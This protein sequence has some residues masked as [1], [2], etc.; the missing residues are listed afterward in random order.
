MTIFSFWRRSEPAV[1]LQQLQASTEGAIPKALFYLKAHPH[2]ALEAALAEKLTA[3]NITTLT[4]SLIKTSPELLETCLKIVSLASLKAIAKVEDVAKHAQDEARFLPKPKVT[5]LAGRVTKDL[6]FNKGTV[7]KVITYIAALISWT[8][9]IDLNKPP[10]DTWSAQSQWMFFRNLI[11]DVEW[12]GTTLLEYFGSVKK[13]AAVFAALITTAT[14]LKYLYHRYN[15]DQ[16]IQLSRNYFRELSADNSTSSIGRV[17]LVQRFLQ[18]ICVPPSIQPNIPILVGPPGVGKTQFVEG[19]AHLAGS[20]KIPRLQGKKIYTV[21]TASLAQHGAW[22]EGEYISRLEMLFRE[23][24]QKEAFV[25]L[26]FDEIH[27]AAAGQNGY[28]SENILES[29]KTKLIERNVLCVLATTQDEYEHYI[30]PNQAI[31]DR[32]DLITLEQLDDETTKQILQHRF[33]LEET[34]VEIDPAALDE[35]IAQARKQDSLKD[36]MN[37]RKSI[38]LMNQ[39]IGRVWSW[40]PLKLEARSAE[41]KSEIQDLQITLKLASDWRQNQALATLKQKQAELK[42]VEEKMEAQKQL[43]GQFVAFKELQR[44]YRHRQYAQ[45][46]KLTSEKELL[47]IEFVVLPAL[48]RIV[49]QTIQKFHDKF[50]ETIPEKVTP[51]VV[52]SLFPVIA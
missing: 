10:K 13:T 7:G 20:G 28:S 3:Q 8:Y 5:S 27:N 38:R 37:P 48:A 35:V 49:A 30:L 21:N 39:A 47:W 52:K 2:P 18:D 44:T 40:I 42:E 34:D 29:L 31:V 32:T 25:I 36:K 14:A 45:V 51:D 16:S 11:R 23:I 17:E 33:L 50:E 15:Y 9:Y 4:E 46:H 41:L 12:L 24:E 43:H 22:P 19:I 6:N 26:F 1:L